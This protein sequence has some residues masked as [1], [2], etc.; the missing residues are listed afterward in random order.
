MSA[1]APVFTIN[2]GMLTL[3]IE[4]AV[5]EASKAEIIR[6]FNDQ[7]GPNVTLEIDNNNVG[8]VTYTPKINVNGFRVVYDG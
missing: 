4:L 3:A 5:A 7:F 2:R 6:Q 1:D 8:A